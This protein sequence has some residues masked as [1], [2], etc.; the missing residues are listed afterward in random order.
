MTKSL[1][2]EQQFEWF[3]DDRMICMQWIYDH[4]KKSKRNNYI[5]MILRF[6][7]YSQFVCVITRNI[8]KK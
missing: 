7:C 2:R 1:C 6:K 4:K 5:L 8:N 3:L